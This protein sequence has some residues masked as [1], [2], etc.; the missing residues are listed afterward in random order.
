MLPNPKKS[1][2]N[3][4]LRNGV[5]SI[6]TVKKLPLILEASFNLA[7]PLT[8]QFELFVCASSIMTGIDP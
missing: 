4:E 7:E 3:T 2:G 1:R 6:R 8:F 5:A